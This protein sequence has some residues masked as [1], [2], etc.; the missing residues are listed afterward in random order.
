MS[1]YTNFKDYWRY[2]DANRT[3]FSKKGVIINLY[4]GDQGWTLD[5]GG[6]SDLSAAAVADFQEQA[7]KDI[8]NLLRVRLKEPG[9]TIRYGGQDIVD[10]RPSTG[11]TSPTPSS[12]TSASRLTVPRIFWIAPSSALP[13]KP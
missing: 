11:W 9:M 7:K 2:P 1:G 4:V 12:A 6:V 3:E 8:N 13:T 10:L 5:K